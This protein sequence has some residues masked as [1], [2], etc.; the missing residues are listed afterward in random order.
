M[1][2]TERI[3]NNLWKPRRNHIN[4]KA[5]I[6]ASRFTFPHSAKE[7]TRCS[8]NPVTKRIRGLITHIK[9]T[10]CVIESMWNLMVYLYSCRNLINDLLLE[11][12]ELWGGG[13]GGRMGQEVMKNIIYSVHWLT[14]IVQLYSAMHL[15]HIYSNRDV[16]ENFIWFIKYYKMTGTPEI[17]TRWASNQWH[18]AMNKDF[19][20]VSPLL[21]LSSNSSNNWLGDGI[22]YQLL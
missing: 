16:N 8:K 18:I 9:S 17:C 14:I 15:S 13:V 20:R 5:E 1:A 19:T 6:Q 10:A 2:D 12:L 4:E 21:D 22:M 7:K 3:I 11:C